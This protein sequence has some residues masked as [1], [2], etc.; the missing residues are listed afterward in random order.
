[1]GRHAALATHDGPVPR[2]AIEGELDSLAALLSVPG[3]RVV[4]QAVAY[5]TG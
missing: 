2:P 1:M 4:E 3:V 5:E